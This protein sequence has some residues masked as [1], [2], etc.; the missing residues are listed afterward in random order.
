V[1]ELVGDVE[2][3]QTP[4]RTGDF[5]GAPVC[6][7]R[8]REELGWHAG[9]PFREGVR[10]YIAW[11]KEQEAAAVQKQSRIAVARAWATSTARM[12]AAV[13]LAACV[14]I[15]ALGLA[16]VNTRDD[17]T[18]RAAFVALLVLLMLPLGVVADIDWERSR[19]RA[20]GTV[21]TL[22]GVAAAAVLIIPTPTYLAGVVHDHQIMTA[23]LALAVGGIVFLARRLGRPSESAPDSAT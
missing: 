22:A 23:L 2:V 21:L 6:G 12:I 7:D 19:R 13:A 8:A 3:L 16:N 4:G 18:D 20:L 14:G 10:R 5:A 1:R 15:A 11:H 9:T 17:P